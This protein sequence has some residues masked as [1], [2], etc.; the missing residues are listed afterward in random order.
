M[1]QISIYYGV[2]I[3]LRFLILC[4]SP[5]VFHKQYR[6]PGQE[7]IPASFPFFWFLVFQGNALY[8]EILSILEENDS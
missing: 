2:G 6:Y 1:A 8:S 5:V 3:F 7:S 4:S